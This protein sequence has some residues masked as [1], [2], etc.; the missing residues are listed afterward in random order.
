MAWKLKI[1]FDDGTEEIVDE[2]FETE[3]AAK[4][5]FQEWLDSWSAGAESLSNDDEWGSDA[6]LQDCEIWEE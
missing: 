6:N 1:I 3:E 5:E 4:D 2:D